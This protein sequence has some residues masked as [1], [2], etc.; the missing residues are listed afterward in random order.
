MDPMNQ[1]PRAVPERDSVEPAPSDHARRTSMIA[2]TVHT[3]IARIGAIGDETSGRYPPDFTGLV[4]RRTGV[5]P[6][7]GAVVL[8]VTGGIEV[9]PSRSRLEGL[10]RSNRNSSTATILGSALNSPS[11]QI[12]DLRGNNGRDERN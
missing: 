8:G 6:R 5:P 4:G 3:P 2:T 1:A 11:A 7:G 9:Q 12:F 10:G